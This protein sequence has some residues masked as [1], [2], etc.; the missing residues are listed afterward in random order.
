MKPERRR[1]FTLV[2]LLVV[3]TIIGILIAL[4][5]PAVQAAREA[6]RRMQCANNVKQI[7][8]ALHNYLAA[9]GVFPMGEAMFPQC[10]SNG[11]GPSWA[12]TVLGYL[13]QQT[14]YD[15]LDPASQT[16][17]WPNVPGPAQHQAALCTVVGA[18]VCPS[19]GR[20]GKYNTD[21]P[22]VT[23]PN[24]HSPN[25][26]GLLEYVGIA[27][28][29]RYGSP[30]KY[31]SKGGTFYYA[32]ATTA[33][34][35]CDGL[36]NTMAVGEYSGTAPG[37][38]YSGAGSLVDNDVSWGLGFWFGYP[39]SGNTTGHNDGVT[40]AVRTVGHPPNTAWYVA[41][42]G[43]DTPIGEGRCRAAL[44]SNHPG[45]IHVVMCDGSVHFIGNGINMA[46]YQDLADRD[47]G[48]PSVS[49]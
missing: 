46:V 43:C 16:F 30:N 10:A 15:Q 20:S 17:S 4:L 49:F 38:N 44:K 19:S 22:P 41:C 11:T 21:S 32:S 45:G 18:Y 29:D 35:I 27:G 12:T 39:D 3:I 13:E 14:L 33:A 42:P 48:N 36:S 1:G 5:L 40:F 23:G 28:S 24:G 8:L 7:G 25:D 6:A 31:P 9:K 47:D 2:E 37:Q 26:F 34:D